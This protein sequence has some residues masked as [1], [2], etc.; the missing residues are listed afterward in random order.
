MG[1]GGFPPEPCRTLPG[2]SA[3]PFCCQP[4][5]GLAAHLLTTGHLVGKDASCLA[6]FDGVAPLREQRAWLPLSPQPACSG[7][8][9]GL[10]SLS[11]VLEDWDDVRTVALHP[12]PPGGEVTGCGEAR[13]HFHCQRLVASLLHG[14]RAVGFW[15]RKVVL[16][17]YD[18]LWCW[19]GTQ[20]G[21]FADV[22]TKTMG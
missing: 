14:M 12:A 18:A 13:H 15:Q 7:A 11:Q 3:L 19:L 8:S 9:S 16:H 22:C 5:E 4:P 17:Q 6:D 10:C 20:M 21:L 2:G 1:H